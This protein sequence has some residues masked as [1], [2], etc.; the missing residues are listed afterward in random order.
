MALKALLISTGIGGSLFLGN[1]LEAKSR[2]NESTERIPNWRLYSL[3]KRNSF[4]NEYN[5][6]FD[7]TE[8]KDIVDYTAKSSFFC[9]N[10]VEYKFEGDDKYEKYNELIQKAINDVVT[11]NASSL[12]KFMAPGDSQKICVIGNL[13]SISAS[14]EYI[15]SRITFKANE[16]N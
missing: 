16:E 11:G 2:Y 5:K 13:L 4:V 7:F 6:C 3:G 10:N 14:G 15:E 8:T 12:D 1:K 9:G